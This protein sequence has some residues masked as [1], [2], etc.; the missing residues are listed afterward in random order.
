VHT[1]N[2]HKEGLYAIRLDNLEIVYEMDE[3]HEK[4]LVC[5]IL[6]NDITKPQEKIR[7]KEW[8]EKTKKS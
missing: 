5:E 1:L 6:R 2:R 4:V 7:T 3:T 8:L